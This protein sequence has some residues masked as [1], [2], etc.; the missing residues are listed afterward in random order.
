MDTAPHDFWIVTAQVI[1]VLALALVIEAR[2]ALPVYSRRG[3]VR[4]SILLMGATSSIAVL[5]ECIVLV[6]LAGF[7]D[8][9]VWLAWVVLGVIVVLLTYVLIVPLV[10]ISDSLYDERVAAESRPKREGT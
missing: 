9:R 3:S 5:T 7:A 10:T 8:G 2:F 4:S 6:V 1:P